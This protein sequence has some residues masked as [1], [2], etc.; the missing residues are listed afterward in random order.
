MPTDLSREGFVLCVFEGTYCGTT[1]S[2]AS[3]VGK[4]KRLFD[5]IEP[6]KQENE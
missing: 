6:E 4:L 1:E 5:A 2:D 3:G